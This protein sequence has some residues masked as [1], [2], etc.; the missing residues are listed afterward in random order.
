MSVS[1][2]RTI[3]AITSRGIG[4]DIVTAPGIRDWLAETDALELR[5]LMRWLPESNRM[6]RRVHR[7]YW[8]HEYTMRLAQLDMRWIFVVSGFEALIST[9]TND[10]SWQFRH[11]VAQ[12]ANEF[13]S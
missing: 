10:L 8:N 9:G 13:G 2:S 4:R 12:L 7:A 5:R 6:H 3:E 11:R 1:E